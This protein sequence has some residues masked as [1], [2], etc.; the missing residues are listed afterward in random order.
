M[1]HEQ[2]REEKRANKCI[3]DVI[4]QMQ[5]LNIRG[6]ELRNNEHEAFI[7]YSLYYVG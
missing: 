2:G 1:I 3:V 4:R 5:N 6:Q 7:F